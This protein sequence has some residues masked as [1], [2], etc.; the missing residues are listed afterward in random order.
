MYDNYEDK[1]VKYASLKNN[2]YTNS[3][4]KKGSMFFFSLKISL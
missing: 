3:F 1:L 4:Y 2:N